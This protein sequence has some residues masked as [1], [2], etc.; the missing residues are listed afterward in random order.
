MV[1]DKRF[2]TNTYITGSGRHNY[3]RIDNLEDP[4]FTSFTFD[5]DYVTSPLFY[6][7]N[8][9]EYGY[10]NVEGLGGRI[11]D[12]LNLMYAEM[13]INDEGYDIL[14]VFSAS[15]LDG[16]KLGFGLQQNV[17]MD[18]PLYGATEYIYMVDKRN[19]GANQNDVGYDSNAFG[20]IA[21]PNPNALNSYSLGDSIKSIVNESDKKWADRM[22]EQN[23]IQI[24]DCNAILNDKGVQEDHERNRVELYGEDGEGGLKKSVEDANRYPVKEKVVENGKLV[25]KEV[26]YTEAE[27]IKK[28]DDLKKINEE[29][30]YFKREIV[31]WANNELSKYQRKG[32]S[33]YSENKCIQKIFSYDDINSNNHESELEREF[34]KDFRTI[35]L[36][37]DSSSKKSYSWNF[38]NLYNELVSVEG[39]SGS[40][41]SKKSDD[42]F[43]IDTKR[44]DSKS[45]I[46]DRYIINKFR[47]KLK[48]FGLYKTE[49]SLESSVY[50]YTTNGPEWASKFYSYCASYCSSGQ[51]SQC[52]EI[53][54]IIYDIMSYKCDY[55]T[56][57]DN[58]FTS[59]TITENTETL[60]K[61]EDALGKIRSN[62]YGQ[63]KDGEY[64]KN[65]PD[66]E[67]I[68]GKYLEAKEKY[69][70]D[71]YSQ[72]EKTKSLAQSGVNKMTGMI[73][74]YERNQNIKNDSYNESIKKD[75]QPLEVSR[76]KSIV[77]SQTVL[78]MLGF[79]SGMK[80]LT[81]KY[82]YVIQGISGLDTAYN[83]H[84]GIKDPYLGSGDD[85]ITL[86]CL[87][88]L[89]L[90][91]SSMFN[92]Y[93]NAV[94]DRQYR[95]ERVPVNLRRFNCIVYVHDVRN[96]MA[97]NRV[98]KKGDRI[99][100]YNR[101]LE[102][103]DMYYSVIEFRFY[104]CEIVP[105]ETGNI[106]NDVS[107]ESPSEMKKTNFTFT[108]GN[109]VVN[110]VPQSEVAAH[111]TSNIST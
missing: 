15:V 91:V 29:F 23:N 99:V 32:T 40:S 56:S 55:G 70:N 62:L 107:N 60:G 45:R 59:P 48:Y 53:S 106:F 46:R 95:R 12:A 64:D 37:N 102:L 90:R 66:P 82:P 96:F 77:A 36:F 63:T 43:L 13:S 18:L 50:V 85:K 5:I 89:D 75:V 84:Y 58:A 35:Y 87:E 81:M 24:D 98:D 65:N 1:I 7:I 26:Y 44:D 110:F 109:C 78:D 92:R 27:L 33:I 69:E 61:Y 14:P 73:G 41:L 97:K 21:G 57:F 11:E 3:L 103:T 93:F 83:K 42:T 71:D 20:D 31:E 108:Y 17:Y 80:N 100:S 76:N 34:T 8:Y 9:S 94:Y 72:A 104:D 30:E 86:T 74:I 105:E 67:S 6:T 101:L 51:A 52:E 10:P 79:I 28:V 47:D 38:I 2:F 88:S 19:G 54:N 68:Y 25:E 16:N 49:D 111:K 4:L 22:I 39:S